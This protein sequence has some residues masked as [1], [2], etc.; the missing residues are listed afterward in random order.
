LVSSFCSLSLGLSF[1]LLFTE[2]SR[3]PLCADTD[4]LLAATTL[5]ADGSEGH[6]PAAGP[7]AALVAGPSTDKEEG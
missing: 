7:R 5:V 2:Q 4:H 3:R 6:K 1:V